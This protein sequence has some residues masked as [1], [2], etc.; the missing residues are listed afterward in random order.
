MDGTPVPPAAGDLKQR[1]VV[2]NDVLRQ[3][4][5][6]E[7]LPIPT[8]DA[9]DG[10]RVSVALMWVIKQTKD[11]DAS[12][13]LYR[14]N[15]RRLYRFCRARLR[16]GSLVDASDVV[17]ETFL[18]I[19][20]RCDTFASTPD[21]TFGGWSIVI[22]ANIIRQWERRRR[23]APTARVAE[24]DAFLD[25]QQDDGPDPLSAVQAR[26]FLQMVASSW[27]TFM[28]ICAA[29]VMGL[30]PQ[31]RQALELR[32][33]KGLSYHEVSTR[34]G[35]SPSH[36]GMLIRRARIRVLDLVASALEG[37]NAES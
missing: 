36:A 23:T 13:L 1:V 8:G 9:T 19:L 29:G 34:M 11:G 6:A 12:D 14:L 22:A 2:L 5:V 27:P 20:R 17:A 10:E 26:E 3:R 25:S 21:A 33:E 15:A 16:I 30:P 7:R 28:Q 35:V 24:S 4:G 37:R 31:W 32:E 18:T